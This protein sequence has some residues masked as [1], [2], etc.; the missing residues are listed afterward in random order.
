MLAPV[1]SPQKNF[2]CPLLGVEEIMHVAVPLGYDGAQPLAQI[3]LD[4]SRLIQIG[5]LG[6]YLDRHPAGERDVGRAGVG[7]K[8]GQVGERVK[9]ASV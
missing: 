2:A 8:V 5:K 7:D 1:P 4:H 6:C 9:H 3:I